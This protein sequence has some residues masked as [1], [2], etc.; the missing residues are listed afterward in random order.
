MFITVHGMTAII[1]ITYTS[2]NNTTG[3]LILQYL[4]YAYAIVRSFVSEPTTRTIYPHLS[5][6]ITSLVIF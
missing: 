4:H 2:H 3:R 1:I 6:T 5:P